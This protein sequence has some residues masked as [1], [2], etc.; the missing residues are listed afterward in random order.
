MAKALRRYEELSSNPAAPL[1]D[2]DVD[3]D[4]DW[5]AA[6]VP[7]GFV[8]PRDGQTYPRECWGLELGAYV[9][10]G[11]EEGE[12]ATGLLG[13]L[14][15]DKLR[16]Y[17]EKSLN[18][19]KHVLHYVILSEFL[20]PS[21]IWRPD[22]IMPHMARIMSPEFP[23]IE[24]ILLV[25]KCERGSRPEEVVFTRE[26]DE[27]TGSH[28]L[29]NGRLCFKSRREAVIRISSGEILEFETEKKLQ[30][31]ETAAASKTDSNFGD[32]E[33]SR[34]A[35]VT[36]TVTCLHLYW[37]GLRRW[38]ISP[39]RGTPAPYD[40]DFSGGTEH[41]AYLWVDDPAYTPNKIHRQWHKWSEN[42]R[43]Y[44]DAGGDIILESKNGLLERY[45]TGTSWRSLLSEL[46]NMMFSVDQHDMALK[47]CLVSLTSEYIQ[48]A[49]KDDLIERLAPFR[50]FVLTEFGSYNRAWYH[51]TRLKTFN[52]RDGEDCLT[53]MLISEQE[54]F[55]KMIDDIP[56][57][58]CIKAKREV[59]DPNAPD[60][61]V[62]K[63][64]PG[65]MQK[66]RDDGGYRISWDDNHKKEK[67]KD[68]KKDICKDERFQIGD[69]V[70]CRNAAEKKEGG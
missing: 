35:E 28:M 69:E 32:P 37:D 57:G 6:K 8:I 58:D 16:E 24:S 9:A 64:L 17:Q 1:S 65:I 46:W 36:E 7:P 21:K 49:W 67:D 70:E 18:R 31:K 54:Y 55:V 19:S 59:P 38:V 23:D 40:L 33:S 63:W 34:T 66:I 11:G 30:E 52:L 12:V 53:S 22:A 13:Q 43:Q 50:K 42:A 3:E 60:V 47:D 44:E 5:T 45:R 20:K 27:D 61:F 10:A 14:L 26:D 62:S 39:K 68:D 4:V 48:F 2:K 15:L 25:V 56:I 29:V 41:K 51:M